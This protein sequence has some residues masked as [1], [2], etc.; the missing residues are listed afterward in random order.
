MAAWTSGIGLGF[1]T[2]VGAA[3]DRAGAD[4]GGG[5][6]AGAGPSAGEGLGATVGV[7]L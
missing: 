6:A 5:A 3:V 7:P 2:L 1:I 4:A